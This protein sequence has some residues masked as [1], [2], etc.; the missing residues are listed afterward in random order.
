M[1]NIAPSVTQLCLTLCDTMDCIH[2]APPWYYP[3]RNTGVGC[4][5]LLQGSS[6]PRDQTHVSC[7]SWTGRQILYHWAIWEAPCLILQVHNLLCEVTQSCPTL[8]DSMDYRL[9][10]SSGN[11]PWSFSG[12]STGVGCHFLLQG[13]FP[14]Q[15]SNLGLPHCR[16]TL[17]HLSHRE[18]H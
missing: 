5:F 17:Y 16:Q 3:G 15:G 2:Q 1:F 9:P 12:K 7:I 14:T 10:G 18:A 6:W 8:G 13:I 11:S 4:H